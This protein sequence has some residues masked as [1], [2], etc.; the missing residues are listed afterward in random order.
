MT[1]ELRKGYTTGTCAAAAAKAAAFCLRGEECRAVAIVLPQGEETWLAIEWTERLSATSARAAVMKDA[2]DDPDV[3]DGLTIVVT[4]E[5]DGTEITFQAGEGVGVVTLPG[6]QL[7]PGEPAI[8]PMP[9]T[10]ITTALRDVLGETGCQVTVSIPGGAEVAERHTF[11]PRLG[12][13]GGLSVLG[14]TGR[15]EPKSE[16]AWLQSLLPQI[17]VARAAG[18]DMLYLVPGGFGEAAAREQFGAP[19]TSII[20]TSN[21]IGAMLQACAQRDVASVVLIGHAG[22]LVKVAAGIFD[23]HSRHGDARLE[24]LA[25]LAAAEGASPALVTELLELPTCEAAVTLLAAHRLDRVWDSLAD[26]AADRAT[27]HAGLPVSCA[28]TGYARTVLGRSAALRTIEAS[29]DASLTVVGIGPGPAEWITPV[30][31]QAVCRAEVVVGGRRHL[32]AFAPAGAERIPLEADLH[33]AMDA[34]RARIGKRIVVLAS[35]DPGCYGILATL[36]RLLGELPWHVIPGISAMQMAMARLQLPWDSVTFASAHGRAC[37]EVVQ[38]A[39]LHPRVLA[40]TD[41]QHTP[42][43]VAQALLDAGIDGRMTV[44]ERLGYADERLTAGAIAEIAAGEFTALAVVCIEH[45]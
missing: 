42:Q 2:G 20:Q 30:A 5:V 39:Y 9:R 36:Q 17:D 8:N 18:H 32:D 28:I 37:Q 24:T 19:G 11:N 33:P 12:I 41:A 25:A 14:T 29:S 22:K 13:Q 15:V 16:D 23:T 40:F 43:V 1:E 45:A 26:R 3:T 35:G 31:W 34:I 38:A 7:A 27:R 44:L 6:L 10:M 21:F 4:L